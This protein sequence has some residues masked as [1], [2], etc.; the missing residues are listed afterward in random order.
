VSDESIHTSPDV[1][2][3]IWADLIER[4]YAL[5][6]DE[7][8]G[9]PEKFREN[10]RHTYFTDRNLRQDPGDR[11][12]D[13]KRSR[14]VI[15][16]RWRDDV[17]EVQE[18]DKITITDRAGIKGPREHLRIELLRDPQAKEFI[19]T[20]LS[21]V[22]PTR[23]QR[24]GTFGVNLFRTYTNVVTSPH[25]DYEEFMILY[26]VDRIGDGA[27]T[28]LYDADAAPDGAQPDTEPV[29][30][31]QLDPGELIILE[32]KRFKHGATPLI[33]PTGGK[34]KRDAVVCS[35]DY[36]ETYLASDQA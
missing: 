26:V 6:D 24:D 14:D 8:I 32:D 31:C 19:R 2:N 7:E 25:H 29:L 18:Y 4:G 33:S 5:T 36:R 27:E 21:L 34:A 23:R 15:R 20:F 12:A 30:R 22:P 28:Y 17:L 11:P 16:Y 35:V 10:F 1:L 3:R 9:L 13:R